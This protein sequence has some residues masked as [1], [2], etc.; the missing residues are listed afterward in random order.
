M[1]TIRRIRYIAPANAAPQRNY[2]TTDT[3]TLT[4]NR[5]TFAQHY[6]LQ[7]GKTNDFMGA[8]TY[9]AGNNLSYTL[10]SLSDGFYYWRVAACSSTVTCGDWS[11]TDT[12]VVNAP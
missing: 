8:S 10:P 5:V 1:N 6:V 7:V 3:S 9:Q 11:A 12:F 4:W 2:F